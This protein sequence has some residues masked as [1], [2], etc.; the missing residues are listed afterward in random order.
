MPAKKKKLPE[1]FRYNNVDFVKVSLYSYAGL[2]IEKERK[3]FRKKGYYTKVKKSGGNSYLYIS[4]TKRPARK[5]SIKIIEQ[6]LQ[7]L[8]KEK[9][10]D[11][12]DWYTVP[13][14]YRTGEAKEIHYDLMSWYT[15]EIAKLEKQ[16]SKIKR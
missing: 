15:Q 11:I 16:K 14:G 5:P 4:K 2:F 13:P 6:K 1:K 9:R 8:K 12:K 7:K 10:Q 3:E